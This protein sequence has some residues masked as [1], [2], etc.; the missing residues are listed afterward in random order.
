[1]LTKKTMKRIVSDLY[2]EILEGADDEYRDY[3]TDNYDTTPTMT[4]IIS[5]FEELAEAAEPDCLKEIVTT[6]FAED[7]W[8]ACG[9]DKGYFVYPTIA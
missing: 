4:N 1:M 5:L 6:V 3:V 2:D 8:K 9:L 7:E